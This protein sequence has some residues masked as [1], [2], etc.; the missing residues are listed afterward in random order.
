MYDEVTRV[1]LEHL[2]RARSFRV[3]HAQPMLVV[4]TRAADPN[5]ASHCLSL[6]DVEY[7]RESCATCC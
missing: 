5:L 4:P 6:F 3:E 1:K 7:I 2:R